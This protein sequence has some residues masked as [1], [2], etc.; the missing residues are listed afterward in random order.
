[1]WLVTTASF[2]AYQCRAGVPA[3]ASDC[4]IVTY[5]HVKKH[6]AKNPKTSAYAARA[7]SGSIGGNSPDN[8]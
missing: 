7:S 8:G 2:P 4:A 6:F 3:D 5:S 1:M